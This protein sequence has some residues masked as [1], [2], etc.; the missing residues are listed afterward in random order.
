M[1]QIQG[2]Y[3]VYK[4]SYNIISE[5]FSL[6]GYIFLE[7]LLSLLVMNYHLRQ[8]KTCASGP[9]LCTAC[10]SYD[11]QVNL[12]FNKVVHGSHS[13]AIFS[14][15]SNPFLAHFCVFRPPNLALVTTASHRQAHILWQK[16]RAH[17]LPA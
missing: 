10:P 14:P 9:L 5:F 15:F 13:W 2:K 3:E 17:S 8:Y 12:N 4:S 7:N 11:E 6:R 1:T 16:C